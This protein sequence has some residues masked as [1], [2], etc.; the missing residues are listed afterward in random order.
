MVGYLLMGMGY[1]RIASCFLACAK[2]SKNKNMKK[3]K[4]S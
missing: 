2:F 1:C 4:A 3:Q